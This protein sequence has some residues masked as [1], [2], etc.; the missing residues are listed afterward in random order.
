VKKKWVKVGQ[1]DVVSRCRIRNM[2]NSCINRQERNISKK[3]RKID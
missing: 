3:K 1:V 2:C